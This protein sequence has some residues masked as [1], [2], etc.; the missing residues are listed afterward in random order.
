MSAAHA[1]ASSVRSYPQLA[2]GFYGLLL[3]LLLLEIIT[4]PTH[5]PV[6]LLGFGRN[7]ALAALDF[8]NLAAE[9]ILPIVLGAVAGFI[10]FEP[11][12]G[13]I[14]LAK[15]FFTVALNH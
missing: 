9:A 13:V 10:I 6:V 11:V 15:V 5:L 2:C 1:R 3:D 8:L 14:L 4:F 7:R 12:C